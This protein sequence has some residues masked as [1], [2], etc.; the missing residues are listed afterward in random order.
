MVAGKGSI[1][2]SIRVNEIET[3]VLVVGGGS[4]GLWAAI[5][6]KD[7]CSRVIV[8]DKGMIASAGVSTMIHGVQAPVDDEDMVAAMKELVVRSAYLADQKWLPI[9][10]EEMGDRFRA[11]EEWGVPFVRDADGKLHTENRMGLK[12]NRMAFINGRPMMRTMKE[13]ALGKGVSLLERTMVTDLLTSDGQHP[14]G[15]RVIG[16]VGLNTISGDFSIIKAKAVIITTG[17][18]GAKR[19]LAYADGLT[20]DGVAMGF[21]AGAELQSME[22]SQS[23]AFSVWDRRFSTGG[24]AEYMRAGAKVINRLGENLIWKYAPDKQAPFLSKQEICFAAVKEILEGRGPVYMDMTNL[25]ENDIKLLRGV[26]PSA[27][28][29]F[30]E[31]GINLRDKPVEITPMVH[32]WGASSGG[33]LKINLNGETSVAGLY[34]GGCASHN[35]GHNV[36]GAG[37]GQAFNFVSGYRAGE[38][39]GRT[40]RDIEQ[41][42]IAADQARS[43]REQTFVPLYRESGP[44]PNEIYEAIN[45]A[46]LP[47]EFCFFKNEGTLRATLARMQ[48]LQEEDLPRLK[49]DDI[50]Q[51]IRA[52]EARN[53]ATIIEP[54]CLSAIEREES[55]FWHYREEFPYRDDV[56]WLKWVVTKKSDG[57]VSVGLESLPIEDYP[58]Q[59]EKRTRVPA[60]IP[61]SWANRAQG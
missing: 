2:S 10:L 34:A 14:T 24:Q 22:L 47:A 51:L 21:R 11:M 44:G 3:D 48:R 9:I 43:L 26:L 50:H 56:D 28:R 46:T 1:G 32:H 49:A 53:T 45:K 27:M 5:R 58:I 23:A 42:P 7:F 30:D 39:A 4:T 17:L 61:F 54:I 57:G 59:P 31:A 19:H 12:V 16:A 8:A 6:A 18:M 13:H 36:S 20:G 33:G 15:G 60:L 35:P 38:M 29:A 37:Q 55:R 25:S 40:S 41:A 52:N